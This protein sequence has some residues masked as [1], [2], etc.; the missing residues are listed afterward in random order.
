M[1]EETKLDDLD[2]N[3]CVYIIGFWKKDHKQNDYFCYHYFH[4]QNLM[5]LD[6][7]VD[8]NRYEKRGLFISVE[9]EV[10]LVFKNKA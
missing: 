5:E 7:E 2:E 3:E 9:N 4:I 6:V 8:Y 1:I 10:F